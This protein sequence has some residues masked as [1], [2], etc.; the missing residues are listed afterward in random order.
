L[1]G[2][3]DNLYISTLQ[4]YFGYDSFRSIQLDIIRSIAS[5]HDT[6]GL[7]PT[8][9]G[10]SITF[11]VPALTMEGVCLVISPLIALMKDQVEHLKARNIK[12]EAIYSGLS[13]HE[14]QRILDNTIFGAVKFLYVSPE[15]LSN[16]LFLTKLTYMKICF[17]VVDEAHCISQWGYDF[18]PPYLHIG[19]LRKT[20]C[21]TM[22]GSIPGNRLEGT[23][24]LPILAL[25]ATATPNVVKDIQERL[26]YDTGNASAAMPFNVFS[27]SFRR[28]N[29]SYVVRHADDKFSELMHIICSVRGSVI[30]Y[31]RNREKTKKISEMI[32]AEGVSAT[33]YHAGLDFAIKEKRQEQWQKDE[34]R[35]MVATN[36][37]GMGIDKPD[38]RL[39]IHMDCP[40][41]IE[42][43]F[44]EAGRAGR[45]GKRAYAVL[46]QNGQDKTSL[47]KR[48]DATFPDKQYIRTVYD[49]LAYFFE[50]AADSGE[51]AVYDFNET[52][53]CQRFK[54]FPIRLES[55]LAILQNAGYISYDLDH[56]NRARVMITVSRNELYY[57][58]QLSK[59]EEKALNALLRNY[60]SLFTDFTFIDYGLIEKHSGLFEE[61]LHIALKG[62]AQRRVIRYLPPKRMPTITYL[63][64]RVVS[65]KLTISEDVYEKLREKLSERI[66]K[67]IQYITETDTCR[68]RMLMEYFG[69]KVTDDCHRCDI[70]LAQ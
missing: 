10:K 58:S 59:A 24:P 3:N 63:R 54:H 4:R 17:I 16:R 52:I 6:L 61:E 37:F 51:G 8:G 65:D 50:L 43:Y 30:V 57:I 55:A 41:S 38:V 46:L 9:G 26:K 13:P 70:C 33:F 62:L 28:E 53:F 18:R 32:N 40:D 25:T 14:I 60:G 31:T 36:A 68:E 27:M 2:N 35:V 22:K 44:Q 11:Q 69:E 34:I 21:E 23:P 48:I 67:M 7:M 15:R 20:I 56:D 66:S 47:M 39:V 12:A 64:Q 45:D 29:L 1:D 42:A 49:H 5:G 19:D